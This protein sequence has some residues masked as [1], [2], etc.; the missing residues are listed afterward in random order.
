MN[1]LYTSRHHV[2]LSRWSSLSI[3]VHCKWSKIWWIWLI[4]LLLKNIYINKNPWDWFGSPL[5][6]IGG[7]W[8][9]VGMGSWEWVQ[10][11]QAQ[12]PIRNFAY[13]DHNFSFLEHPH[14]LI[15]NFYLFCKKKHVFSILHTNFYKIPTSI[16]LFYTFIQ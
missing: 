9:L 2:W 1:Y 12:C 13:Q 7:P 5:K 14:Q 6:G 4:F 11:N 16:C 8:Q 10:R 15:H 3:I